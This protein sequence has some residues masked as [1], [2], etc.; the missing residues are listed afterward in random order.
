MPIEWP[1]QVWAMNTT[2]I[3]SRRSFVNPAATLDWASRRRKPHSWIPGAPTRPN[4]CECRG[5]PTRRPTKSSWAAPTAAKRI[6]SPVAFF[7]RASMTPSRDSSWRSRGQVDPAQPGQGGARA[8]IGLSQ[9]R[10]I[11]RATERFSRATCCNRPIF[12]LQWL[13]PRPPVVRRGMVAAVPDGAPV[14]T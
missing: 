9:E 2:Q 8:R 11:L 7:A 12:H 1:N 10:S 6:S 5:S 13:S 4:R 14:A 3:A